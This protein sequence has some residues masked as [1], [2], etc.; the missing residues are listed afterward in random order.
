[1]WPHPVLHEP[2]QW[3]ISKRILGCLETARESARRQEKS[4]DTKQ[5]GSPWQ[6]VLRF[7]SLGG[8]EF[9]RVKP[10]TVL[11]IELGIS[12]LVD[13]VWV[14]NVSFL[15]QH[16]H[17]NQKMLLKSKVKHRRMSDGVGPAPRAA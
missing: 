2:P 5:D 15:R 3:P 12:C 13:C 6:Y 14:G 9:A 1:M 17:G 11:V 16:K 7:L 4:K 10:M 8:V